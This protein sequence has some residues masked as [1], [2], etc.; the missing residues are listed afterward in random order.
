MATT[1]LF[2]YPRGDQK[3]AGLIIEANGAVTQ[4]RI[5]MAKFTQEKPK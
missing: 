2:Y 1:Y 4:E 5:R 3:Q